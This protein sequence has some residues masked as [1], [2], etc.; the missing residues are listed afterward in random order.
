MHLINGEGCTPEIIT[1]VCHVIN[2]DLSSFQLEG[3]MEIYCW[4]LKKLEDL[5]NICVILCIVYI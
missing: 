1:V 5:G 2:M 3:W 4:W